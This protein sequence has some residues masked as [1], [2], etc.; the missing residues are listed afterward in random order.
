MTMLLI[1]SYWKG[2][3]DEGNPDYDSATALLVTFL[4]NN[5]LEDVDNDMAMAWEAGFLDI[6]QWFN[7]I[8][9]YT[10]ISYS[11][12]VCTTTMVTL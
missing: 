12:E 11:S 10:N 8:S 5:H 4:L 2:F 3:D 7:S 1:H 9:T 6:V